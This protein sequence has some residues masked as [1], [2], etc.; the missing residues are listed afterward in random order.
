MLAPMH[1]VTKRLF[2]T[3]RLTGGN[4][5]YFVRSAE[6]AHRG[7][8]EGGPLLG[9]EGQDGGILVK[10]SASKTLVFAL[11]AVKPYRSMLLYSWL[12]VGLGVLV[13]DVATPLVF[14][15]A[16]QKITQLNL[17]SSLWATFGPLLLAYA[18]LLVAGTAVWRLAG[19]LEWE[20]CTRA[21]S[22]S[23]EL[24]FNRLLELGYRWHVDHAS[25]EVSSTLSTFSWALME[26]IDDTTWGLLRI[27]L[28]VLAAIVVLLIVALP[29]GLIVALFVILF[30]LVMWHFSKPVSVASEEFSKAHAAAEGTAFDV[31]RNIAT[32][33]SQSTEEQERGRVH[34][35]LQKSVRADLVAR[36]SF[37]VT[38]TW[39]EGVLSL[40]TWGALMVGVIL[41]LHRDAQAGTIYLILYYASQVSSLMTES[42]EVVRSLSRAMGRASKLVALLETSPDVADHPAGRTLAVGAGQIAFR[43]VSFAYRK[44]KPVIHELSLDVSPGEHVGIVGPSGSGKSTLTRLVMRF[45]DVDGGEIWIDGQPIHEVT[46]QSLRRSISYVPQDP[47]MLHR[48]IAENI[49]YGKDGPVDHS[50]VASVGEAAHVSE[51][52][53]QLPDGYNTVVGERGMKLSGGQRQRV[54]IAQAMLKNARILLLDE[55]TSALDSESERLVQDALWKLMSTAT[56][57]VVAHRLSTISHMDRIAVLENGIVTEVGN[58]TELLARRGKYYRLWQHQ[59]GGFIT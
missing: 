32:V 12:A 33:L 50:Q 23:I 57:L 8:S 51:F 4:P 37:S 31:I 56:A 53:N 1:A 48:T 19:W 34:D 17:H 40:M 44:G 29:V 9:T 3:V 52:V 43:S 45:M 10:A 6:L 38:R 21:F 39:M 7:T 14:A 47:Q 15:D 26:A 11:T 13:G 42:F 58:H 16:L 41:A 27:A 5:R 54:A 2:F 59:S 35:L 22:H 25:G 36:R 30:V 20:G 28:V 24:A 18:A 55:A 49:W 46:Q